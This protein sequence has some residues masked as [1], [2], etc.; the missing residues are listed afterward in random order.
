MS[1]RTA[2]CIF[3]A[4]VLYLILGAILFVI[5]QSH[6]EDYHSSPTDSR[7]VYGFNSGSLGILKEP[8]K[9]T[10]QFRPAEPPMPIPTR[11]AGLTKGSFLLEWDK[12]ADI[13]K[14]TPPDP[15][16]DSLQ[17][18][19]KIELIA[20][21]TWIPQ[22]EDP[23]SDPDDWKPELQFRDAKSLQL[24]DET[25]IADLG[26]PPE[27]F[28]LD[29]PDEY[30]TPRLSLLLRTRGMEVVR[31]NNI[32]LGDGRTGAKVSYDLEKLSEQPSRSTTI[33]EWTR[34]DAA[35]LI[36]HDSPLE[37]RTTVLTGEPNFQTLKKTTGSQVVFGDQ[38]RV[39]WLQKLPRSP[40]VENYADS[41]IPA[42]S[43]PKETAK[44]LKSMDRY[45]NN[46]DKTRA[47]HITLKDS[48]D[49]QPY[50]FV[51]ASSDT[52]LENHCGLVT[53]KGID[54][55]W[56]SEEEDDSYY[57]ATIKSDGSKKTSQL[58]FLPHIT[59]LR[60]KIPALPNLPNLDTIDDL[61]ETSLPRITLPQDL[62][63]AEGQ[64]FGYIGVGAQ[65]AWDT[66]KIWNDHPPK[67]LPADN[68]FIN[69]TPQSL[70]DWYLTNTPTA[71]IRYDEDGLILYINEEN[72]GWWESFVESL[73][74]LGLF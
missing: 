18:D 68:T 40:Y 67:E 24:L 35:M 55:E 20:F 38:L 16:V 28:L 48:S 64:L 44:R 3:S 71:Q 7:D 22:P 56:D 61:F 43:V 63:D 49:R 17:G 51:R 9:K 25:Q 41:F 2:G 31:F 34:L 11:H 39:Q 66:N 37:V 19:D 4:I 50:E 52:Y 45:G 58:V 70:L 12:D 5:S 65:V 26:I 69:Q 32:D 62:S 23:Y 42:K 60:F 53:G 30:Q 47:F 57:L 6:R 46:K 13:D 73:N 1:K 59:E 21:A 29:A 27:L 74:F 33:K 15:W 72:E 36:F 54:W 14:G 10:E 8:S